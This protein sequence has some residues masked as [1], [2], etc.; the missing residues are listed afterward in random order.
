MVEV[1]LPKQ[2]LLDHKGGERLVLLQ[3]HVGRK[4][5]LEFL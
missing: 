2:E 1:G 4:L 3:V 5:R